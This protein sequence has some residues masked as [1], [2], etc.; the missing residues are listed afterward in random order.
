ML[1]LIQYLCVF[2]PLRSDSENHKQKNSKA[3]SGAQGKASG[4]RCVKAAEP[5]RRAPF[6]S[7]APADV[8]TKSTENEE[9]YRVLQHVYFTRQS[10]FYLELGSSSIFLFTVPLSIHVYLMQTI[11][12]ER[13]QE[14]ERRWKAEQAVKT[15]T[16]ELKCL[17]T[18]F[19]E[20]KDLQNVALNASER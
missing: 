13:D 20:E 14:K 17:Q 5:P 2:S 1:D 8:K 9:T 15:L 10:M 12:E 18:K 19:R 11:V 6:R 3:A 4:G 16:E 7:K